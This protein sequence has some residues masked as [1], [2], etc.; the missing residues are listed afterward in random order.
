MDPTEKTENTESTENEQEREEG[1]EKLGT[2]STVETIGPC[3]RRIKAEVPS[4][5][6]TEALDRSYKEI[7]S[8]FQIPGFRRGR[9]PRRLIEKRFGEEIEGDIK[10]SLLEDSF[11]EVVEENDLKV[12]GKPKFD[13]VGFTKGEPLRYEVEVE[14]RPEF[15]L[16]AYK[17]LNVKEVGED[18]VPPVTEEKIDG[19]I[20]KL[21]QRQA[22][23]VVIDPSTA[24]ADDFYFGHYTLEL[25][26]VH[27][28]TKEDM[29]FQP[30]S[31]GIDG[32]QI[33]DL[34]E[35]AASAGSSSVF[36]ETVK[37]PERYSEEV[38]R[39][40]EVKFE[41]TIESIK[42]LQLPTVDDEF[43]KLFNVSSV[44]DLRAEIRKELEAQQ[45]VQVKELLEKRILEQISEGVQ[46][47]L[48][49]G[50]LEEHAKL[51]RLKLEYSLL[52]VGFAR[53]EIDAELKKVDEKGTDEL[54]KEIKNFFI[55]EKIA[56]LEKVYATEDDMNR[57][58]ALLAQN[59]NRPFDDLREELKESGRIETIRSEIRHSKVRQFLLEKAKIAEP[60]AAEGSSA[61][62][63]PEETQE[64]TPEK[65][66]AQTE[67]SPST[68]EMEPAGE[69]LPE[70]GEGL[71]ETGEGLPEGREGLPEG[72]EGLPGT[73]EGLP[74]TREASEAEKPP[75]EKTDGA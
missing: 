74:G 4:E 32:F 12:I 70:T 37:V 25:D 15:E 73:R 30:K 42:R 47:D 23:L 7:I 54:R 67:S 45:K 2:Q 5:K 17:G 22:D 39:G 71:P 34:A 72:Q 31:G 41:Y 13:N 35:K 65:A 55:L 18:E 28:H 27:V 51:N 1:D 68:A 44:A 66:S 26:G 62:E 56:D 48:P 43:A 9:V 11:Q 20:E 58:I 46:F 33:P 16:G 75:T 69:G 53:E 3:K 64:K 40:K 14:V 59:Q 38:L 6:V 52:Q 19:Q 63:A 50:F 49:E 60:S 8:T 10:E 36:S 24:T 61:D 29:G 57:Q 21:Q